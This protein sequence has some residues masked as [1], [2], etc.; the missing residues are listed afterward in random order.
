MNDAPVVLWDR[1]PFTIAWSYV[2]VNGA[3]VVIFLV[4]W[5]SRPWYFH[6][7]LNCIHSKYVMSYM[8]QHVARRYHLKHNLSIEGKSHLNI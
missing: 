5:S 6:V 1:E 2:D 3:E 4:S 8:T 7:Q